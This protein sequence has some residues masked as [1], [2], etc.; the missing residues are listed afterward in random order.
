[1]N[2]TYTIARYE[3]LNNVEFLVAFNVK[4]EDIFVFYIE[5]ILP[6]SLINMKTPAEICQLAFTNVR[7]QITEIIYKMRS[8]NSSVIGSEF[9]PKY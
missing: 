5:S 4:A 9:V 2:T 1:M 6:L 3:Q 8:E 7:P